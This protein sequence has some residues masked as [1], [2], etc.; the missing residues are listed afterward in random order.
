MSTPGLPSDTAAL[1]PID[2]WMVREEAL[3]LEHA[4]LAESVFAQANGFLGTRG[5]FEEGM[6]GNPTST[7]GTY[8]NGVY[9]RE[10]YSYPEIAYAFATHNN[11]MVQAPNGKSIA[12]FLDGER[13]LPGQSRITSYRRHMDFRTGVLERVVCWESQTGKQLE[14]QSKRL[15]SLAD[16]HIIAL[17]YTIKPLNFDGDLTLESVLDA[18]Y[19]GAVTDPND[20]R[21]GQLSI[22]ESLNE[23]D[24]A[25]SNLSGSFLHQVK[26]GDFVLHTA[27]RQSFSGGEPKNVT[28][29]NEAGRVGQSFELRVTKGKAI[30]L[31]KFIAYHHGGQTNESE[32]IKAAEQSLAKATEQGF[33][34]FEESQKANLKEFWKNAEVSIDGDAALQQGMHFN[35]FHIY[36]SVGKDGKSNIAA[37]GLTGPGYDGH[38][39]WDTEIYVIPFLVFSY[40]EIARKLLEFRYSLL[41]KARERARQMSHTKGALFAWRTIGG[42]ECSA[43]FPAGTAQYHINAAVAYAIGQYLDATEDWEFIKKFGA[44]ILWDTARIWLGIGHFNDRKNGQF[45]IHEVTGPDE[46]SA[47]VD[48]N[49]YTNAMARH[50]LRLACKVAAHLEKHDPAC[51]NSLVKKIRLEPNELSEWRNAADNMFLPYDEALGINPQDDTFL[52]K[53]KWD[54]ASTPADKRPLLI[55]YHPLVIYRHQVLKQTDVV[56]AMVLL[57]EQFDLEL[58][59]RNFEYYDPL[60]THDST[61]ST[62]INSVACSELGLY[63]KAYGYFIETARMDLDNRHN[64][65]D[66]GLHAACM[67]GS[68][69]TVVMGFG[70]MRIREGKPS[71]DPYLPDA[72]KGYGFSVCYRGQRLRIDVKDGEVHYRLVQGNDMRILHHGKDLHVSANEPIVV[73]LR[74][75]PKQ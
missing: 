50:H 63:A 56:L 13:F 60:T 16:K 35:L 68:W 72:W 59:R 47:M 22:K 27:Y 57:G 2:S 18:T 32:L 12:L 39:F 7:E 14:V 34:K 70:G 25:S 67:A 71:F 4:T 53:P 65:T 43:Y 23:K 31:T 1:F 6:A 9:F 69:M 19:G 51:Y 52:D 24:R 73:P 30:T 54:I 46:Y 58:K 64:N 8:L 29:I 38:Y 40:P 21:I 48:N 66:Y 49:F 41:D 20:P 15:V 3:N 5:T 61:L 37:K 17:R 11:K 45:C 28:A 44:E 74:G 10:K 33:D 55:H 75:A 62:S 42:E 36:Q 26:G